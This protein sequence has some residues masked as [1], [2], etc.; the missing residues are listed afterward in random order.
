[1]SS[2]VRR[3][4]V[5]IFHHGRFNVKVIVQDWTMYECISCPLYIFWTPGRFSNNSAQM[6]SMMRGFAV[7]MFHLGRSRSRS[8]FKVK[9]C[10]PLFRVRSISFEP[11]LGFSNNSAQMSSMMRQC[12]VRLFHQG[13]FKV[14]VIVQGKT[15]YDCISCL[16]FIFSTPCGSYK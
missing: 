2:M 16:L 1:M 9:Q 12:A 4:A 3:C 5:R 8:K 6:P 11:L 10:M 14:K 15:L 7:P 13:R